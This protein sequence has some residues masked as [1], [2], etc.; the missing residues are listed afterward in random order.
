MSR[1]GKRPIAVPDKVTAEVKDDTFIAKGP[2][3]TLELKIPTRLSVAI[4][5]NM[6]TVSRAANDKQTKSIHGTTRALINNAL[7]G[8]S[9]GFKRELEIVGV[10]YKAQMKGENLSMQLGFSH[11]VEM[12]VPEGITV[13]VPRPTQIIIEGI[14]KHQVGQFSAN[15]RRVYPPEPYKG[16]GIRYAGEQVRKKIGKAMAK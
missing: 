3:G 1:I 5:D 13:S 10:G 8:V 16:K 12:E 2:K 14:D 4:Q 9:E 11:L 15:I 6:V 7:A